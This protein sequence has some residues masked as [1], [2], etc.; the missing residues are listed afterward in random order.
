MHC[1]STVLVAE[2]QCT[3]ISSKPCSLNIFL[4]KKVEMEADFQL[5][6]FFLRS[7]FIL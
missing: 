6:F 5:F 3:S 4:K 2:Y 1:I 7:Q